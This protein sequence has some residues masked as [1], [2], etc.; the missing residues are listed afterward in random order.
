MKLGHKSKETA[1]VVNAGA[2]VSH[3][4]KTQDLA[5]GETSIVVDPKPLATLL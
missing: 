5:T 2:A 1:P 4:G 3:H